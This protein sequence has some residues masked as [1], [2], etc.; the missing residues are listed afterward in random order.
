[1]CQHNIG[2]EFNTAI[3]IDTLILIILKCWVIN[4]NIILE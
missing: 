3:P 4:Y 2:D 1:M